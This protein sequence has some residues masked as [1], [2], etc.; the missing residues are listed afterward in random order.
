MLLVFDR[1]G[2]YPEHIAL[3]RDSGFQLVTYEKKPYPTLPTT[4]FCNT[5][6]YRKEVL[7]WTEGSQK[8]LRHGRGRV[9]RIALLTPDGAQVNVLAIS[10]APAPELVLALL[11]RWG[12]Q[13]NQFKHE[14]ERWGINQL[15]GRRVDPY[16][17]DAVIPNP[18]RRRLDREL[19]DARDDEADALRALAHLPAGHRRR[20]R[21][22]QAAAD[23]YDLQCTIEA[24]RRGVPKRAPLRDTE[25]SR[26]LRYHPGRYKTVVDTLRIAL[27]NVETDL[28][29]LLAPHLKKPREA[30]KTLANLLTAA[31]TV[32]AGSRNINISLEPAATGRERRAFE[33]LLAVVNRRKLTLPGDP[34]GRPLRFRI[35]KS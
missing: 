5:L 12:L 2:A 16:P 1:A 34:S 30:K 32:R 10:D 25:L 23:A 24:Q 15:D 31:G 13:E 29:K 9:R 27:A 14:K 22:E 33:A 28:A 21:L 4:A 6:V 18:A 11:G 26:R 3:L 20:D 35:A 7:R 19:R 17:E 8:N